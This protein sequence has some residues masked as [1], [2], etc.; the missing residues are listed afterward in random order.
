MDTPTL[1]QLKS[2][3][4]VST[5]HDKLPTG[6]LRLTEIY[7]NGNDHWW[8]AS[9]SFGVDI[10]PVDPVQVDGKTVYHRRY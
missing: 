8:C 9:S 4:L 3:T 5:T 10:L 7:R 6:E 2:F 1:E